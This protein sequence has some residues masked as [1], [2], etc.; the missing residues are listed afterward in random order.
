MRISDIH[1]YLAGLG[2]LPV[3]RER[4]V[5]AWLQAKPL[6]ACRRRQQAENF[7]PLG[8]R[9]GLPQLQAALEQLARIRSQHPASDGSARLLVELGDGQL[10]ESVLLK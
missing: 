1:Q 2:A 5:R 9:A 7:L 3:H 10:V 8:V 4:V 6:D